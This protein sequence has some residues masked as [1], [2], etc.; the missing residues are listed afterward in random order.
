MLTVGIGLTVLTRARETT[1]K[2]PQL[3]GPSKVERAGLEPATP[4]LQ[5]FLRGGL[6]GSAVI[7]ATETAVRSESHRQ[8]WSWF[9]DMI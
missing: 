3:H 2:T 1:T 5:I 7:G 9:V 6:D 8:Q 4:S